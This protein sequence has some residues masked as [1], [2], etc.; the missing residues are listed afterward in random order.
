MK[1]TMQN[2]MTLSWSVPCPRENKAPGI[3]SFPDAVANFFNRKEYL[4]T[5]NHRRYPLPVLG[6]RK[7]AFSLPSLDAM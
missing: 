2:T 3:G 1:L 4:Q 7:A 6:I 5:M